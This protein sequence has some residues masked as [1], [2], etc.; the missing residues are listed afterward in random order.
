[1]L[2]FKLSPRDSKSV[3]LGDISIFLNSP[4]HSEVQAEL[5]VKG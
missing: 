5:I 3:A 1:M 2:I 4:V